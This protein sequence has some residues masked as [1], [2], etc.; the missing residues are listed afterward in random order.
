[1]ETRNNDEGL[2]MQLASKFIA[3]LTNIVNSNECVMKH[4]CII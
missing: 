1:M 4:K 2:K 3:R